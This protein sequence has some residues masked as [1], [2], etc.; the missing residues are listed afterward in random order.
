MCSAYPALVQTLIDIF[1]EN[2]IIEFVMS[3]NRRIDESQIFFN[4]M[5]DIGKFSMKHHGQCIFSFYKNNT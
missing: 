2:T 1:N 3:W 5:K 4:M